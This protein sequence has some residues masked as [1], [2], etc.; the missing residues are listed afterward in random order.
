MSK[1]VIDARMINHSGIG[2]YLQNLIPILKD[3]FLITLLGNPPDLNKFSW[4][5]NVKIVRDVLPIYSIKEQLGLPIKIKK[6]DIFWSPHYNTPVF[7]VR[8]KRRVTTI[9]DL[10]HIAL[11]RYLSLNQKLYARFMMKRAVSISDRII[12]VS[13]FS[14]NEIVKYT[15]VSEKK[16]RVIYNGVNGDYFKPATEENIRLK[17]KKKY[18][19]PGKYILYVGNVKPHKNLKSLLKAY[20]KVIQS[21]IKD[22]HLVIVGKK[23]GYITADKEIFNILDQNSIFKGKVFFTD[24]VENKDLPVIYTLASL[25]VFP[26]LY[27]GFGFP[28]LESMACGC[29]VIAANVTSLPE[30]CGDAACYVNPFDVDD[31]AQ[32]MINILF[33][34]NLRIKLIDKGFKRARQFK[35]EKS[36]KKHVELFEEV[37]IS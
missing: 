3:H 30:V 36:T 10:N 20:E 26:S 5:N 23:M 15:E 33:N 4:S 29:P 1:L 37:L 13:K 22:Y 8:S 32:K 9:H 11:A 31:I 24:F 35:W 25:F 12:T 14:R 19:L 21:N 2:I 18:N 34:E 28:P 6:T 16:I 27:E 17:V 7:P